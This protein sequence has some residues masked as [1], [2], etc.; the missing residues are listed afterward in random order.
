MECIATNGDLLKGMEDIVYLRLN[1]MFKDAISTTE[2]SDQHTYL[3]H[4]V[5]FANSVLGLEKA[6]IDRCFSPSI[7]DVLEKYKLSPILM[8]YI[9]RHEWA[10]HKVIQSIFEQAGSTTFAEANSFIQSVSSSDGDISSLMDNLN[11]F[12]LIIHICTA[13]DWG[14]YGAEG[15]MKG[16]FNNIPKIKEKAVKALQDNVVACQE[17]IERVRPNLCEAEGFEE[18]YL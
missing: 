9:K 3:R 11:C 12:E 15:M 16:K 17:I 8:K 5:Q 13:G 7:N 6:I 18:Q 10:R 4:P 1:K 2:S 14:A